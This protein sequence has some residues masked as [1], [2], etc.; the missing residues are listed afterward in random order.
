[1]CRGFGGVEMLD[2]HGPLTREDQQSCAEEVSG[3]VPA[4]GS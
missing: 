1:M 3:G 4:Q 2:D